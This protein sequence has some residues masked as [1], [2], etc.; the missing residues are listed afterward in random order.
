MRQSLLGKILP[1]KIP[2]WSH[3]WLD[4]YLLK[5]YEKQA[6]A[7]K[8]RIL[9]RETQRFRPTWLVGSSHFLCFFFF[10]FQKDPHSWVKMGFFKR[11]FLGHFSCRFCEATLG[12]SFHRSPTLLGANLEV[13]AMLGLV[14]WEVRWN[15]RKADMQL[16]AWRSDMVLWHGVVI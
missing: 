3:P 12:L 16:F 14:L 15:L 9:A 8:N 6:K 4:R 5:Y 13:F 1:A 7:Q 11:S 2:I 10:V